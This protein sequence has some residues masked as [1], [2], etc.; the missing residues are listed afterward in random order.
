MHCAFKKCACRAGFLSRHPQYTAF[1]I[2]MHVERVWNLEALSGIILLKAPLEELLF[3]FSFGM[4]WAG[5]YE[6]FTWRRS[7]A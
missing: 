6:H 3:A 1:V 4:Y 5:V 2:I 7:V